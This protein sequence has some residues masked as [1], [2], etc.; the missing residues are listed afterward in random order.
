MTW[1]FQLRNGD[2][3]L[4]GA[5]YATVTAEQKLVQDL[6]AYL[7][8][9]MGT[10]N[11]HPSFGSLMDGGRR[12]DGTEVPGV[13]GQQNAALVQLEIES[14]IRRLVN[15]YQSRQLA[16]AQEDKLVYGKTTLHR[17]E[18]LLRLMEIDFRAAQDTLFITLVIETAKE[19]TIT[20]DLI[21]ENGIP[22]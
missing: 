18:V 5:N 13:I 1:S 15:D 17:G 11:M 19:S 9:K 14:D 16:R 6:R 20:L 3:A 22:F 8:E 4:D 12:P 7:L 10:D 2:L 21:F